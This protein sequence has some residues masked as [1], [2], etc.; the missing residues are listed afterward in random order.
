[1]SFKEM[2]ELALKGYKVRK[3]WWRKGH[4][5]ELKDNGFVDEN[6]EEYIIDKYGTNWEL[7]IELW[8]E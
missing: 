8:E 4:Y 1:M 5:I 2:I 3:N 6:G 7:Y